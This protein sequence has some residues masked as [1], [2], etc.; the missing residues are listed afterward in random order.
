[1]GCEVLRSQ[2]TAVSRW[3]VMPMQ[4]ISWMVSPAFRTA[5]VATPNCVD[6]ISL[7]SCSTQP[8]FGKICVNSFWATETIDPFLS[9][10]MALEL[11]VP[12]SKERTYFA[13]SNRFGL[14]GYG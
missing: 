3:L 1:M 11:V 9:K 8:G 13:I 4:A 12:W 2:T 6:Q 7:A 14:L 5:S 10:I